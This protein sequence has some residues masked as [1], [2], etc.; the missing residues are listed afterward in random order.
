[1]PKPSSKTFSRAMHDLANEKYPPAKDDLHQLSDLSDDQLKEFKVL[2][3]HIPAPRRRTIMTALHEYAEETFELDIK[4]VSRA[5]LTD[6]DGLVRAAAACNL[7]ED[8]G[9]DLIET[10]LT[11]LVND[12]QVVARVAAATALGQ[13]VYLGEIEEID[14]SL[15]H[16]VEEALLAVFNGDDDPQ[17]R[18]HALESIGFSGRQ[19]VIAA[20]QKGYAD[21]ADLFKISA[22]FAM[23]RNLDHRWNPIVIHELQNINPRVRFEAARAAGELQLRDAVSV[24][25]ELTRD[26]DEEVQ[27]IVIWSLGEIGGEDAR[28]I[29]A[30]LLKHAKGERA[31]LIDEALANAE[32]MDDIAEFDLLAADDLEDELKR[33]LN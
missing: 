31:E 25:G 23:G 15:L 20:I 17:V 12:P 33:R 18:R 13:Y 22:L 1:M 9:Q 27:E 8:E 5:A 24:L 4:A 3:G 16:K 11:M 2:W 32:L 26:V 14:E 21:P 28:E 7:W 30:K 6:D 29:L 19:E 10:F